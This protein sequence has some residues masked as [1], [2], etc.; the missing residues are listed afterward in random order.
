MSKPQP[1]FSIDCDDKSP[2]FLGLRLPTHGT[3]GNVLTNS[4]ATSIHR[5]MAKSA[6]IS[7]LGKPV[8]TNIYPSGQLV[9]VYTLKPIDNQRKKG[10]Y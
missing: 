4:D 1:H 6:V 7:R 9:Y 2:R 5:G 8:L 3:A 10:S